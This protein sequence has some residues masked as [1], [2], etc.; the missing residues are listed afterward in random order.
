MI[1]VMIERKAGPVHLRD[2]GGTGLPV[3]LMHDMAAHTHWWDEV[4]PLWS[5]KL[6]AA[7]LRIEDIETARKALGW[8]RFLLCGHSMGARIALTYA[9]RHP[10]RLRG[11]AAQ[12]KFVSEHAS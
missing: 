3:P 5:G 2:W 12:R 10:K 1:D 11:V 8:E 4:A 7:D 6:R 9:Q